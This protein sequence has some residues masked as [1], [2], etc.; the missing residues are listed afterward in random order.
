MHALKWTLA[1]LVIMTVLAGC[2]DDPE[3][4]EAPEEAVGREIHMDPSAKEASF[5]WSAAVGVPGGPNLQLMTSSNAMTLM[6]PDGAAVLAAEASWSCSTPTCTLHFYLY[7]PG[8]TPGDSAAAHG[9]GSGS[10]NLSVE[11]PRPGE[12]MLVAQSDTPTAEVEGI[13]RMVAS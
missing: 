12:W 4:Q 9:A 2:T 13:L 5:G 10:I 3:A 1:S 6:V 11:A 7:E 8:A